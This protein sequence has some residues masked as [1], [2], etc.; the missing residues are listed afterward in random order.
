MSA[1]ALLGTPAETYQFG[2]MYWLIGIAYSITVPAAAYLY[3]PIFYKLNVMSAFEV[4]A[5]YCS[6]SYIFL[7][8]LLANECPRGSSWKI[9]TAWR[10]PKTSANL[11]QK[12]IY[13]YT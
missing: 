6:S 4:S 2:T 5:L 9:N 3:F 10:L 7:S 11:I 8:L 1:I 12:Y 13:I